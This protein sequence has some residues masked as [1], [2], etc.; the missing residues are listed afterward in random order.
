M[1]FIMEIIIFRYVF[2]YSKLSFLILM[3]MFDLINVFIAVILIC[4]ERELVWEC[5]AVTKPVP[6]FFETEGFSLK[7]GS[8]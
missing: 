2:Y 3:I 7:S 4:S 8:V 6:A 5:M 1:I